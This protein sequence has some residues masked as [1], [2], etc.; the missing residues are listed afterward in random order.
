MLTEFSANRASC[1]LLA[2]TML[3]CSGGHE[4]GNLFQ[5]ERPVVD[6]GAAAESAALVPVV[7]LDA[8]PER[9]QEK[10]EASAPLVQEASVPERQVDATA[11]CRDCKSDACE[12]DSCAPPTS[13]KPATCE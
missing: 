13:C 1:T 8:S 5:A 9:I 6:A 11:E 12:G 3:A 10:G 7:V 2:S 4:V